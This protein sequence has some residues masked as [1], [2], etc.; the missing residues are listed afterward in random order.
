MA[1]KPPARCF[2]DAHPASPYHA[3]LARAIPPGPAVTSGLPRCA[4]VC[5]W[6]CE[7]KLCLLSTLA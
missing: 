4:R 1:R 3:K 2:V 7:R 5:L 6:P